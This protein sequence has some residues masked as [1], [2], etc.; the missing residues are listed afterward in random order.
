MHVATIAQGII[1]QPSENTPLISVR[2]I[3]NPKGSAAHN[4]TEDLEGQGREVEPNANGIKGVIWRTKVRGTRLLTWI[5]HPRSWNRQAIWT[6]GVH[7][8]VG[9]VPA[10]VLGLLLNILDALS[11]GEYTSPASLGRNDG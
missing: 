7:Q 8:P 6:Y 3:S 2:G 9:Y 4:T 11:Y 1:S 10:V 5:Y